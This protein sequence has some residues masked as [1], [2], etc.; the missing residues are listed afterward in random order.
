MDLSPADRRCRT[1]FTLVELLVTVAV[2]AILVALVLPAASGVRRQAVATADLANLRGLAVAHLSYM[3]MNEERFVDV[4]LPHGG[5]GSPGDSFVARLRPWFGGSP[6]AL[7]SPLDESP[8]WPADAGGEGIPLPT[9]G[10]PAFRATSYG[11]NNYLS[12]SYSP[13]VA[14]DGPGAGVDRLQQVERPE[15]VV[16]FLLMAER[17]AY[18]S[19]D[20]PHVESWPSSAPA[21]IAAT[22]VQ[23]NAIDRSRPQAASR[24][25]Y[26]FVDGHV[27]TMQF[28]DVYRD[29]QQNRFDPA[30]R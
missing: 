21:R 25:N 13:A 12:R 16:C 3:S 1:G 18:A 10:A 27:A 9:P 22:Q 6:V 8:H 15:H 7:R 28:E 20:H 11:M 17:G 30:L 5:A 14:L 26:S 4:G 24:S 2:I 19:A 29:M 23:V